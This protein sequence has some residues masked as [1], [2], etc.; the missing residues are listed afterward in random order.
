MSLP[1]DNAAPLHPSPETM[2]RNARVGLMLFFVYLLLYG[3]FMLLNAFAPKIMGTR[4]FIGG[5]NLAL[6]YGVGLILAAFLLSLLYMFLCRSS[7]KGSGEA[8][9]DP[10]A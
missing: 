7:V 6:V 2:A 4:T 1:H 3:G 5:A 10:H 9:G 8:Q